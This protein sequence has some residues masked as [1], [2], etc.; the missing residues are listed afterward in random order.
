MQWFCNAGDDDDKIDDTSEFPEETTTSN[1]YERADQ[2]SSYRYKTDGSA[3]TKSSNFDLFLSYVDS[4]LHYVEYE[5]LLYGT[6]SLQH[7]DE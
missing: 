1:K 7:G 4:R 5:G 2:K 3:S 6:A